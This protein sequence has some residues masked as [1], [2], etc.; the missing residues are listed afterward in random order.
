MTSSDVS[1]NN[2]NPRMEYYHGTELTPDHL[3]HV[4]DI[5]RTSLDQD[6]FLN[7]FRQIQVKTKSKV[8][9]ETIRQIKI[10]N[11][12]DHTKEYPEIALKL[13]D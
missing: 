8:G 12:L 1:S 4:I 6:Q 10:D 13:I 7:Y 11:G 3:M 2:V 5:G 9:I